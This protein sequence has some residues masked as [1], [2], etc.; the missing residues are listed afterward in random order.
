MRVS[1]YFI[2]TLKEAPSDAEIV[3]HKLMMRAGLIK[4]LAGGIYTWMPLGLRVLRKVEAIVREEM[5]RA[6]AIELS[7]PAVQPA[8]LWQESGRW[9]KYGPEL[10]RLKDRHQR[11]FVIG[12]THEEVITDIA[13]REIKS[14]RQLPVHF[15]QI[16]TKF[17]DEIRPRFGV[18]RGR[19]FLM[20]DGYSFHADHEDLQREYRNMFDAYSRIFTRLGLKFRAVAADTGSIGGSGSHEFHVLADSGEDA[21]AYCPDSDYAANVELAEALAPATPRGAA[22]VEMARVA[23][24]EKKRCEDVAEFLGAPLTQTVKAIAVMRAAE[25]ETGA[26][27]ALVLL[28]GDH[29]LNE[30]KTQKIIGDFRFARDDE[31]VAALGCAPGY[32]GPV[33]VGGIPVFADR[34]VAAMS[35]FICGA[36]VAG[37]HLTGVNFGRDLSEPVAIADLRN[38]VAGD[39]SPDGRG[40]LEIR[41]GIE[42]GHIFQLRRK[43][44]EAMKC[45]FLD[46]NG[47]SRPME[48]GCY[49]IGISRIV[50]AAIEQRHDERGIIFPRAIAPFEVCVVPMG[51]AKNQAV[52]AAAD[53]LHADLAA[54]GID[55][56]LDD[57][58]ERPGIQFADMELIGIPHRIVVGERGL[59][60]GKFEYKARSG[61]EAE[62]VPV[63]EIGGFIQA[64]LCAA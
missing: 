57:R 35:D 24:P 46:E 51:Y 26:R 12:P 5:D 20:K 55:V 54:A 17:R 18:M 50:G 10:L 45:G 53:K 15:Y 8:E 11:D 4:R 61:G 47:Q 21:L 25:G 19:E 52:R 31:I 16:Q 59:N 56:L 27:F 28:R 29:D 33:G 40:R 1:N 9:E 48:M 44:S 37:Y 63:G 34:T 38:V 62:M 22:T 58:N 13:R 39:P 2:S 32:I 6:G 42:V 60:E 30:I 43:Y 14:Y 41:R 36:N 7:M 23:T 49:G 64:R 3:S